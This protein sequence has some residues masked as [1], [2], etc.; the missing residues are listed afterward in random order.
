MTQW[1][2]VRANDGPRAG[3]QW[4]VAE[5]DVNKCDQAC[6]YIA[7]KHGLDYWHLSAIRMDPGETAEP[8]TSIRK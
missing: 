3:D 4:L 6:E 2:E 8:E 5:P 1:F 7:R